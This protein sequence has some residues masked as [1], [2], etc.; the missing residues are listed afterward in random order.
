MVD[1]KITADIIGEKELTD[2]INGVNEVA[3]RAITD[4]LNKTAYQVESRARSKAPHKTGALWGS[5]HTNQEPGNMARVEGDNIVARVG[6]NLEYARAQ[7]YGTKGMIISVP[8]GRRTRNGGMTRP[9]TF[10]GNIKPKFY[11]KQAKE[12]VAPDFAENM[13]AALAII[14]THLAQ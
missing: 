3:Q 2:A 7:E 11:M 13:R 12:D 6:T 8:N 9:Y 4:A 5:L 14:V 1:Y 10:K